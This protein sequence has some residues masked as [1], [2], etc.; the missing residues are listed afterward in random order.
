VGRCPVRGEVLKQ[1]KSF[2]AGYTTRDPGQVN[3]F[4]NEFFPRDKNIVLLGTDPIECITGYEPIS[5]F[6]YADWQ[7][8]GDIRLDT[9]HPVICT[10]GNVA[11]LATSGVLESGRNSRPLRFTAILVLEQENGPFDTFSFSG[12]TG[13]RR[14][15]IFCTWE[16]MGD[17]TG[18]R[19]RKNPRR[20]A[21]TLVCSDRAG[22]K[23]VARIR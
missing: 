19:A 12:M 4:M 7:N 23:P 17:C 2:Q 1:L 16:T 20:P 6:T 8:W 14:S 15:G 9:E 13:K 22:A 21:V 18:S 3:Q 11:W 5:Q 10:S